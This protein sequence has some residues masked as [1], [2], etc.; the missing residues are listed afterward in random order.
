MSGKRNSYVTDVADQWKKSAGFTWDRITGKD[1]KY[2]MN[3]YGPQPKPSKTKRVTTGAGKRK[4]VPR[5]RGPA[6][7]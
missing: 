3:K 2:L 4:N 6:G 7:K 5:K 1:R